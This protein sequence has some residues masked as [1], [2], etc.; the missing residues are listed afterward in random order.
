VLDAITPVILTLDEEPNIGRTL[1]ALGWAR[2]IVVVDS[3]SADATVEIARRHAQVRAFTRPF[4]SHAAQWN[5]AIGAT[6]IASEWILA[7]DADYVLTPELVDELRAL[8]AP[9]A[10]AGYRTRFVYCVEG[11]PL[12]ASVYPPVLTLFRRG[13][14]TYEQDGHT[15]RLRL[16]GREGH[17]R[18]P[19]RHDDRKPLAR[20]LASQGRYMR[21][22]ARKLAA[23]PSASLNFADRL[24]K[25]IVVAP[26]AVLVY[27]LFVKGLVLDGRAGLY[28]ALQRATAELLLSLHLL[29]E[30]LGRGKP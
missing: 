29:Q 7:L 28:Y 1:A 16:D 11:R 19:I 24:R 18:H 13:R 10:I 22:E 25:A 20:W 21:L 5:H 6:G 3:G 12:R 2:D 4:D 30:R 23:A 26:G 8:A 9:D 27:L 15:Q 17:L 14:G